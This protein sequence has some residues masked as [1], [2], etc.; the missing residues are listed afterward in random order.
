MKESE[1]LLKKFNEIYN[2]KEIIAHVKNKSLRTKL[3]KLRAEMGVDFYNID[4]KPE[5]FEKFASKYIPDQT[6][7]YMPDQNMSALPNKDGTVHNAQIETSMAKVYTELMLEYDQ[8]SEEWKGYN[9]FKNIVDKVLIGT[10]LDEE[11]LN[12]VDTHYRGW[13]SQKQNKDGKW[14]LSSSF[15]WG[16]FGIRYRA[17]YDFVIQVSAGRIQ[18]KRCNAPLP[19]TS[20][21][22]RKLFLPYPGGKEQRFCSNACKMRAYRKNN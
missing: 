1:G 12:H 17:L 13:V 16:S 11:E 18:I 15:Y 9:T 20:R 3:E 14:R 6:I 5:N 21:E 22:C 19:Y 2:D 4:R 10:Q 8:E 7:K